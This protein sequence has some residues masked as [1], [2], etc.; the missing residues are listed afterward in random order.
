MADD[1][2]HWC[3]SNALGVAPTPHCA[4]TAQQIEEADFIAHFRENMALVGDLVQV[5]L[6]WCLGYPD[7]LKNN[8][9]H[10]VAI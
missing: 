4:C 10:V 1:F 8:R 3:Q 6:L 9:T 5:P 7:K 2:H